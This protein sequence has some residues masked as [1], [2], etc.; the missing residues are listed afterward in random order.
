MRFPL[1][2]TSHIISNPSFEIQSYKSKYMSHRLYILLALLCATAAVSQAQDYAKADYRDRQYL[3]NVTYGSESPV[4]LRYMPLTDIADIHVGYRHAGGEFHLVDE[5]GR[6]NSWVASFT[7]MKRVSKVTFAG[8]L[9]YE[10]STL[11]DRCWNNTLF[12]S[13]NNPYIIA[14]SLKSKFG[15]EVFRLDGAAAYALN[16]RLTL[17]LRAKYDVGSSATQ[18]DPRPEIKGMRF[19]LAPGVEYRMGRHAVGASAN[20]RWLSEQ[21]SHTV[22]RTT[23]KQYVFLFQGLGVY[24]TK[25]A[26]GYTR[27]YNGTR[28]GVQLQYSLN[29]TADA[30]LSDFLQIEY[31]G[32]HEDAVD[33]GSNLKYKGGR[34]RG[35]GI[36]VTDRL[37]L[38]TSGHMIH[39]FTLHASMVNTKGRWYTQRSS[40]DADGNLIYD[41][42]NEA[43]HLEGNYMQAGVA[44]RLDRINASGLPVFQA[45]VTAD[46][47][48]SETTN[49]IYAAKE[50]YTNALVAASVTRRFPIKKG[51][52]APRVNAGCRIA[53]DNKLDISN[54]PATYDKVMGL[55][56]SP[57]FSVLTA[58]CC[59]AGAEV[60]YAFPLV[61]MKYR[62]WLEMSLEGGYVGQIHNSDFGN[63]NRY[64][65]GARVG[66]IF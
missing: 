56:T 26:L 32:E 64:Y 34:Y 40:T 8:G 38:R 62:A 65:A 2:L 22:L 33:G 20:V 27:K 6:L 52:L 49:K 19:N 14:D 28:Y 43:D 50:S 30:R 17:A 53:L 58:D 46:V 39:N 54:M 18:K 31:F 61:F 11:R 35:S 48:N 4:S 25:D 63:G 55:Y 23:T 9:V 16:D 5:P 15:N 47:D 1:I 10:N 7:G 66:F 42:I 59:Q 24:E 12:I 29:N 37:M 21:V 45:E 36:T 57:Q 51:W 41:V 13:P 44:Y 3:G 60:T